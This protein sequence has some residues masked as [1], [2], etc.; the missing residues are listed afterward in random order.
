MSRHLYLYLPRNLSDCSHL[1]V[2]TP[3]KA[4]ARS[5]NISHYS[6]ENLAE[7]IVRKQGWA[8]A[9]SLLVHRILG[10]AIKETE[11]NTAIEGMAR[12]VMPTLNSL[13]RS[14][15]DLGKLQQYPAA[16]VQKL[17]KLALIYRQKLRKRKAIAPAELLWQ[18]SQMVT[19]TSSYLFYGYFTPGED[20][21]AFIN[22]IAGDNSIMV[23][24]CEEEDF[25]AG[26]RDKIA[27]LQAR[28]WI[29]EQQQKEKI[30]LGEQ[31]QQSWL[32]RDGSNS[33]VGKKQRALLNVYPNLEAEVRGVL[34]QVKVLLT[35]GV[36]AKDIVLVAKDE[37]LYGSTLLD[38]AWEYNLP[39]RALY[40]IPLE[41]TRLGAWFK[42]LLEVIATNFPFES[43]AKL[44]S[45]PLAGLMSEEIWQQARA[46]H[47]QSLSA[48]LEL[49]LD[50]S[51][52]DLPLKNSRDR[53][54][55]SLQNILETFQVK[56]R[57][58]KWAREIVA[59]YL[60]Q[61]ALVQLLQP[62]TELISKQTFLQE[63]KQTLALFT[64]PVQPG[65]G[66]VELHNPS[67]L[68]G[69]N[70]PYVFVLGTAEGIFPTPITNDPVLD[71]FDRK[72]LA[73]QGFPLETA[74][75]LAQTE[76]LTFYHL[77]GVPTKKIVFS[78]P[79]L[80]DRDTILPS[81]YLDRLQLKS[82][83]LPDLPLA[84]RE[85]ARRVYLQQENQFEDPITQHIVKAWQVEQKRE[86]NQP[87]DEY[88]GVVGIPID[89]KT[90]VFSAS[91]LTQL[92]QCPF[93]WFA[94][95]LLRLRE[96]PEAEIDL[97]TTLKGNLYHR[98]LELS[99][100]KIKT[101][102]D[103]AKFNT[104]QL[105]KAFLQVEQ[106]LALSQI[107]TWKAQRQEHLANLWLNLIT[108]NFLPEAR[109]IIA[110][111]QAF[112]MEWHGLP[113]K[114]KVDR[115]DRATTG[116]VILDYKTSSNAPSGIKDNNGKAHIDI[117]LPLYIDAVEQSFPDESIDTAA[118][119]SLNKRKII[120]R[121]KPNKEELAA[122]A[123]QVKFYL[124]QGY[125]PVAPDIDKK[126]CTY[127]AFDL[128]CRKGD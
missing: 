74:V 5:L 13:F 15:V 31:L 73:K 4:I 115:I 59:F 22:A 56:Q 98:C 20:Q 27:Y 51:I 19:S 49:G 119:Y 102:A 78:Y 62:K 123:E 127:C 106:D 25:W 76:A 103:L 67:S 14:G 21:I 36:A 89:P 17:A 77:L 93:K 1:Q 60:L 9:S 38:V 128:V 44:L 46:K 30:Y 71:F 117:Q 82:D 23:L 29:V 84:S 110:R 57:G 125:Y 24:P 52:L 45:H 32:T 50:L 85:E 70:Y 72:Q 83:S 109:E 105:E 124:E 28:G 61:D 66:G 92:G 99:L 33:S 80:I 47:P 94:Y 48:W 63:V 34:T 111:E 8:I 113:V 107:S 86:S 26:N 42:L 65:R 81:P 55:Q 114:G 40:E 100:A 88:G 90:R 35:E 120:K 122:F 69:A 18:G 64:V 53:W 68:F 96:L 43:T 101:T 11:G 39:L 121:A 10:E 104:E 54:L 112:E 37:Q 116:L 6:L 79:Q 58:K 2:I 75:E 12:I 7:G 41:Q 91:Q 118:Y 16:R 126:A 108:P 97:S 87:A 3:T 95:R